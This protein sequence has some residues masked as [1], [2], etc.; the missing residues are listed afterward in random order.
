MAAAPG[1]SE[2]NVGVGTGR[3]AAGDPQQEATNL[4]GDTA[5]ALRWGEM[6]DIALV[7]LDLQLLADTV[8]LAVRRAVQ[9]YPHHGYL[10]L[11]Y[12]LAHARSAPPEDRWPTNC[13]STGNRHCSALPGACCP[14]TKQGRWHP[15]AG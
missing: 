6:T 15:W 1:A 3:T 12:G 2:G 4:W 11:L 7:N 10:E 8:N 9:G 5:Y 13:W 14:L